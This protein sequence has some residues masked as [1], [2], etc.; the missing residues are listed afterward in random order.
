MCTGIASTS[1]ASVIIKLR[2]LVAS[3]M[4]VSR[5]PRSRLNFDGEGWLLQFSE[6]KRF[7]CES[8]V[9]EAVA[10]SERVYGTL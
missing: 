4:D 5:G 8:V 1:I 10:F 7:K 6:A 2:V 3:A 9:L